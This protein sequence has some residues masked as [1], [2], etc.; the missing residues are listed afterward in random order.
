MG[1]TDGGAA[2]GQG[3]GA[4]NVT[5]G[6]TW[7]ATLAGRSYRGRP[8]PSGGWR[9]EARG[10]ALPDASFSVGG[11]PRGVAVALLADAFSGCRVRPDLVEAFAAAWARALAP[12]GFRVSA[13]TVA[14]W[15]LNWALERDPDA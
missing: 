13:E 6:A 15:A 3:H 7:P 1:V 14:A 10:G 4:R 8:L 9:I 2:R 12:C 5:S 11:A